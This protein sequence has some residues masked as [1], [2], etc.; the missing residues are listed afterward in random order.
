MS[1]QDLYLP[2]GTVTPTF[3]ETGG[4]PKPSLPAAEPPPVP[5][6]VRQ[7]LAAIAA[8][9]AAGHL[10]EASASA[11]RLDVQITAQHGEAHL[12]TIQIREVRAHL[13]HLAG[14]HAG[15][16]GWYLHTARL[17]ATVQGRGHADTAHATKLVYSL[18]RTLPSADAQRLGAELLTALTEIHGPDSPAAIRTRHRLASLTEPAST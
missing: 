12:H 8:A 2:W 18:W 11:H 3:W 6:A 9:G 4:S 10:A 16:V 15:A 17:R 1:E 14:D 5:E 7:E 13:A